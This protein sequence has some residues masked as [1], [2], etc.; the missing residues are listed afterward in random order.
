M[1]LGRV[2]SIGGMG[3]IIILISNEINVTVEINVQ[4]K[5]LIVHDRKY[6]QLLKGAWI[7][8]QEKLVFETTTSNCRLSIKSVM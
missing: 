3:V 2:E 6:M 1:T 4:Y 7:R 5:K 8:V